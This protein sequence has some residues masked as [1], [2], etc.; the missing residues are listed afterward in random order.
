MKNRYF[1]IPSPMT[2]TV[3]ILESDVPELQAHVSQG[4]LLLLSAEE[5][6][7]AFWSAA[8]EGM[9]VDPET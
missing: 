9:S 3:G 4:K 2:L 8:A 1:A 7:M 5:Y 6:F